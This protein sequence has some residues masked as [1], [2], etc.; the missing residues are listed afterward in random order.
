MTTSALIE[1]MRHAIACQGS[2]QNL[3]ASISE[4]SLTTTNPVEFVA[5]LLDALE[6]TVKLW[7]L[8]STCTQRTDIVKLIWIQCRSS[9]GVTATHAQTSDSA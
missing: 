1:S 8:T 3:I 2:I 7:A 9:E 6:L 5:S 4:V